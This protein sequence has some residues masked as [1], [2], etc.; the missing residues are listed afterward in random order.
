MSDD[1]WLTV[2]QI[3]ERVQLHPDTVR[4]FL[5]EGRLRG[6]RVTR[7]AGWRVRASEV[8]RFIESNPDRAVESADDHGADTPS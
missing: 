2:E 1:P 3:A 6:H 4:R 7:R 5:R 8:D